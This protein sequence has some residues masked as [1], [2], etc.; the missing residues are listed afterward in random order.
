MQSGVLSYSFEHDQ[1]RCVCVLLLCDSKFSSKIANI[2]GGREG[3]LARGAR[4]VI[5]SIIVT[6]SLFFC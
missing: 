4:A 6:E 3:G 1:V 2:R 5:V